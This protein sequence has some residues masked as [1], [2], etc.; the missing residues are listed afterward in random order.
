MDFSFTD[1]Q[2]E[3]GGLAR[4]ILEDKVTEPVLREVDAAGVRFDKGTWQ[5]LADAGLLGI[6]LPVE[7]GGGGYGIVEQCVVLEQVGRTVAPV[8]VAASTVLGALPIAQFGSDGLRQRWV[9]AAADGSAIL[10]AAYAEPANRYP[11]QP[12]TTASPDGV[13][14][15]LTG[16]KT[17]VP[18]GSIADAFVVPA[19]APEGPAL[20]LVERGA[21]GLTVEAQATTDRD[22]YGHLVLDGVAVPGDAVIGSV[23]DGREIVAWSFERA[24]IARCAEML[25]VLARALEMTGDYTKQRVQF[26]RP[27][28]TFQAVGHRL[29]DCYIDIEGLRLTFWQAM[30]LLEEGRPA[31]TE[32]EVAK[33]WAA[34]AAH[35]VGH[36]VVHV[37]GGTGIDEDYPLHRYFVAAKALEFALGGAT[38]QLLRIGA[39]FARAQT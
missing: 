13:G 20:F 7:L 39:A 17:C 15:R 11:E 32:V 12:A 24:T 30:W 4:R 5:A 21:S 8:P 19:T 36:A 29:A 38:D 6:G 1:E 10:T 18:A 28:A 25:G 35:R 33:Y 22:A 31:A 14:W 34:E 3:L 26:D 9:T 27:I 37:H 16:V 23:A 2:Q